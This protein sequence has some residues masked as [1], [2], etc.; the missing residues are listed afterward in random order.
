M[1]AALFLSP[2]LRCQYWSW[3]PFYKYQIWFVLS[4]NLGF[5]CARRSFASNY[6]KNN[7]AGGTFALL[8]P[9]HG[10]GGSLGVGLQYVVEN[11]ISTA[12]KGEEEQLKQ[13]KRKNC[14]VGVL[15]IV[16]CC[17]VRSRSGGLNV[18]F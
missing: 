2:R 5:R 17:V 10:N 9:P 8:N 18:Y 13:H 7:G 14:V 12:K 6:Y 15:E 1:A 4:S 3:A 11:K 16:E